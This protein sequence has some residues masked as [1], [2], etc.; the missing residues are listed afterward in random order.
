VEGA[1][2]LGPWPVVRVDTSGEVDVDSL[3]ME[4]SAHFV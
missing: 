4:I 2:P 1:G 3:V